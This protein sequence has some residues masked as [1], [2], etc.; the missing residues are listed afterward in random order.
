[1]TFEFRVLFEYHE[2]F[3]PASHLERVKTRPDGML[4]DIW[5]TQEGPCLEADLTYWV[6]F[7]DLRLRL[8]VD[9]GMKTS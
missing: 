5:P 4:C 2:I 7:Y 8:G 9:Y 3:F 1:M 6:C